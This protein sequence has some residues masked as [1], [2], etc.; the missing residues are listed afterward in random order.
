MRWNALAVGSWDEN[1][2]CMPFLI[3]LFPLQSNKGNK[4]MRHD[5]FSFTL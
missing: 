3:A 5:V 1:K 2:Y 4:H